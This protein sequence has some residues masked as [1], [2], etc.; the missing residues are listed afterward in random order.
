MVH[1]I[2]STNS[3]SAPSAS[4]INKVMTGVFRFLGFALIV[5]M[6]ASCAVKP[7]TPPVPA[8]PAG[9]E[10][11]LPTLGETPDT[12]PTGPALQRAHSRWVPVRWADLPGFDAD[13]TNEAWNAWIK[14]CERPP[15]T[16]KPLCSEV[17]PLSEYLRLAQENGA[18]VD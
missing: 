3:S 15:A 1:Q 18:I 7:P 13:A 16:F 17:R 5:G 10:A 4:R 12:A 8:P 14:S 9:T 2:I 6:L 11:P